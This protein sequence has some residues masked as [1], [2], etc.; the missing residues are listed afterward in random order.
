KRDP[1]PQKEIGAVQPAE[2]PDDRVRAT[3]H[4]DRLVA[5]CDGAAP[6][7]RAAE[8]QH[9]P[10]CRGINE[11]GQRPGIGAAEPEVMD[12]VFRTIRRV[13]WPRERNRMPPGP[14]VFATTTRRIPGCRRPSGKELRALPA[15]FVRP[16]P[17]VL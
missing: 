3:G 10:E 1:L 9:I 4:V 13:E 5:G 16:P 6:A 8:R 17:L 11:M 7:I 2:R 12:L 15:R 14:I